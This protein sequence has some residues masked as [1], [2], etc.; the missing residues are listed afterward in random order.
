M[1]DV[2]VERL[3]DPPLDEDEAFALA[4]ITSECRILHRVE[5]RESYLASDGRRMLCHFYAPDGEAVRTAFRQSRESLDALW[6]ATLQDVTSGTGLAANAEANV[7]AEHHREEPL[8]AEELEAVRSAGP[9]CLQH[10]GVTLLRVV[11]SYD[12]RR[13]LW[14]FRA[15]DAEVV[16]KALAQAGARVWAFTRIGGDQRSQ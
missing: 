10:L 11:V 8:T 14:L 5:W 13:L 15:P 12:H 1:A 4:E 9:N 6:P 7:L 3:F 16:R 2:F